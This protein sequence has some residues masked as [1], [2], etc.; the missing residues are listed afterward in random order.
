MGRDRAVVPG[1]VAQGTTSGK[2]ITGKNIFAAGNYRVKVQLL[3][4][5]GKEV[6]SA[7]TNIMVR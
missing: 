1:V 6:A 3:T 4:R 5:R 7:G 2:A